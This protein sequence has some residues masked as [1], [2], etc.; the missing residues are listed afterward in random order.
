M[1]AADIPNAPNDFSNDLATHYQGTFLDINRQYPV[2]A[3]TPDT[4]ANTIYGR[5][6][7][8]G[9]FEEATVVC[10]FIEQCGCDQYQT[11][12]AD[13]VCVFKAVEGSGSQTLEITAL[14]FG[15]YSASLSNVEVISEAVVTSSIVQLTANYRNRQP[16]CEAM[17]AVTDDQYEVSGM[18]CSTNAGGV[19]THKV[20]VDGITTES[21]CLAASAA[22][23]ATL[24]TT[25][26]NGNGG[27]SVCMMTPSADTDSSRAQWVASITTQ[28]L[29]LHANDAESRSYVYEWREELVHD[30][31]LATRTVCTACA[32]I[33][34]Q[35]QL[36]SDSC[37]SH[38]VTD[39]ICQPKLVCGLTDY[40]TNPSSAT[41]NRECS[42]L[43][44]CNPDSDT[45]Q[46]TAPTLVTH[47]TEY[48][49]G[50]GQCTRTADQYESNRLCA[51]QPQCQAETAE[52][53]PTAPP[54]SALEPRTCK[55][56]DEHF[57]DAA[58]WDN[59]AVV[60]AA[61]P[62]APAVCDLDISCNRCQTCDP[63]TEYES[64][65]CTADHDRVCKQRLAA[66]DTGFQLFYD[67]T[68]A[69]ETHTTNCASVPA[70]CSGTQ[71]E[72][73]NACALNTPGAACAVG[74][75]DCNY[76]PG[77]GAAT[78]TLNVDETGCSTA[79]A[80]AGCV[81]HA[82]VT[83]AGDITC[84]SKQICGRGRFEDMDAVAGLDTLG[85][86]MS[87]DVVY[88]AGQSGGVHSDRVCKDMSPI[89]RD[90][91][92]ACADGT[93]PA[94]V[95]LPVIKAKFVKFNFGSTDGNIGDI[96][97]QQVFGTEFADTCSNPAF[98]SDTACT[99]AAH[100]WATGWAPGSACEHP[101]CTARTLLPTSET[102]TNALGSS[103]ACTSATEKVVNLGSIQAFQLVKITTA[104]S[105]VAVSY[106]DDGTTYLPRVDSDSE[107]DIVIPS[108]SYIKV[109]CDADGGAGA[110]QLG[111][112]KMYT[113]DRSVCT[114]Q[115]CL[116]NEWESAPPTYDTVD[117]Q[118]VAVND[119]TCSPL[120]VCDGDQYE[121]VY[122]KKRYLNQ[123]PNADFMYISQRE[124]RYFADYNSDAASRT[125]T[126]FDPLQWEV[127]Y[128]AAGNPALDL[129]VADNDRPSDEC[130]D[131]GPV[132]GG[133][134]GPTLCKY[135]TDR[136]CPVRNDARADDCLPFY[137]VSHG[138][139]VT[140]FTGMFW[141]VNTVKATLP[142]AIVFA[143]AGSC[144]YTVDTA[145]KLLS[146][147]FVGICAA[148]T[149]ACPDETDA[150]DATDCAALV[151][152]LAEQQLS[153]AEAAEQRTLSA[154]DNF[155][156]TPVWTDINLDSD[157]KEAALAN[158]EM[159]RIKIT[160][161]KIVT[162][163]DGTMRTVKIGDNTCQ[164]T[165]DGVT[166]TTSHQILNTPPHLAQINDDICIAG[167]QHKF[168]VAAVPPVYVSGIPHACHDANAKTGGL[169]EYK[170]SLPAFEDSARNTCD[171]Y[172][173]RREYC[174]LFGDLFSDQSVTAREACC[175]CGGGQRAESFTLQVTTRDPH[176][177]GESWVLVRNEDDGWTI[178]DPS[179][180]DG[181]QTQHT[182]NHYDAPTEDW[183]VA[184]RIDTVTFE[185]Y[186]FD[187]QPPVLECPT[188]T[189]TVCTD[190]GIDAATAQETATVYLNGPDEG[191]AADVI[192][193]TSD[194]E[195][196]APCMLY[197]TAVTDNVN[198]NA[199]YDAAASYSQTLQ[200]H[201]CASEHGDPGGKTW[202]AA[203]AVSHTLARATVQSGT[204]RTTY[205]HNDYIYPRFLIGT[206]TVTFTALDAY[207][208]RGS[209]VITMEVKDCAPPLMTCIDVVVHTAPGVC[210]CTVENLSASAI[211]N[212]GIL[213]EMTLVEQASGRPID[214]DYKF[215]TGV[216]TVESIATDKSGALCSLDNQNEEEICEADTPLKTSC[217][218]TVTCSDQEDPVVVSCPDVAA[219][220]Q[221]GM[222]HATLYHPNLN[223][224][225]T[226][227][228]QELVAT[229][230]SGFVTTPRYED[231]EGVIIDT[232]YQFPWYEE[233]VVSYVVAD[234][235][236]NEARCS[237][238][239]QLNCGSDS[240]RLQ[241]SFELPAAM[242]CS[243]DGI[244]AVE[245]SMTCFTAAQI[246]GLAV[247]VDDPDGG[248]RTAADYILLSTTAG[249][250]ATTGF[251]TSWKPHMPASSVWLENDLNAAR[252]SRYDNIGAATVDTETFDCDDTG[253]RRGT[254]ADNLPVGHAGQSN[255]GADPPELYGAEKFYS[256]ITSTDPRWIIDSG[257]N[258]PENV[259]RAVAGYAFVDN[260]DGPAN[261]LYGRLQDSIMGQ[262]YF[263]VT[264]PDGSIKLDLG[265]VRIPKPHTDLTM[266][267]LRWYKYSY[268]LYGAGTLTVSV[269]GTRR[270][271]GQPTSPIVLTTTSTENVCTLGQC[272][273]EHV[274]EQFGESWADW[275]RAEFTLEVKCT[276]E[277]NQVGCAD[278]RAYFDNFGVGHRGCTDPDAKNFD[279]NAVFE[280]TGL[281]CT[282]DDD[283]LLPEDCCDHNWCCADDGADNFD[284]KCP[285]ALNSRL[286]KTHQNRNGD[287]T[288]EDWEGCI[289]GAAGDT[290]LDSIEVDAEALEAQQQVLQHKISRVLAAMS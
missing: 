282:A 92:F 289:W 46:L 290:T 51:C 58:S 123:H 163:S 274:Q 30:R 45:F 257:T 271:T 286:K 60:Y 231:A 38:F 279:S 61:V 160:V 261:Q 36:S 135:G 59:W 25:W 112:T 179:N 218:F 213:P 277:Q 280:K 131:G 56:Q 118:T 74:G 176:A 103:H 193:C 33:Q 14:C 137:H 24:G 201:A 66:C 243:T 237:F 161:S 128:L 44:A 98:L 239:V 214:P 21:A 102:C 230:N 4:P 134:P 81:Y 149:A 198:A 185:L 75:G 140:D 162:D 32:Y 254:T 28:A 122:P 223:P 114:L 251:T 65:P 200:E 119:R 113:E 68:H 288:G 148:E 259:E 158:S 263:S 52:V 8:L 69:V 215:Q 143:D 192:S 80:A 7:E 22:H 157:Q 173:A 79:S 141:N 145:A 42:E 127:D 54:A 278:V 31:V 16:T 53:D 120:T 72:D 132:P 78:C 151:A 144:Y 287:P 35:G 191:A 258:K 49:D 111:C 133:T 225:G 266:R 6:P 73:G 188:T 170:D 182:N 245:T 3:R 270:D 275:S 196:V 13:E 126:T 154:A 262:Q 88:I 142:D 229:D 96:L 155:F 62:T 175:A 26:Q 273:W 204:S 110:L 108:N 71:D 40:V 43:Q 249:S 281:E 285:P 67:A 171:D 260:M 91:Q 248:G 29:C 202:Q 116:C 269:V 194:G 272:D 99:G 226:V 63:A 19:G 93:E 121:S 87:S 77:S 216:T 159:N 207:L 247:L 255:R 256:A 180:G 117:G 167:G 82:A 55:C 242:D 205:Q 20:Q 34:S 181:N 217:T 174:D 104:H 83:P 90:Y 235:F 11:M 152:C 1:E 109:G 15:D 124:C 236:G 232:T 206:Y 27:G 76:D 195:V 267:T 106:S 228:F 12:P 129:C 268:Q 224:R 220:C 178:E 50:D 156:M 240:W 41:A 252:S 250:I 100:T 211:D 97:V 168:P 23:A 233:R 5:Y 107:A 197:P 222:E 139:G 183:C 253:I 130:N 199:Q 246:G 190:G 85:R 150:T 165:T 186:V 70:A 212:S 138:M 101:D 84:M 39:R 187:N 94:H 115:V 2:D 264:D 48:N 221:D 37:S 166:R 64:T 265:V 283:G 276:D 209:C 208:N 147:D 238:A 146:W 153:A 164:T 210:Y 203:P 169:V 234:P 18:V 95:F 57:K 189:T 9:V 125:Y 219:P 241:E 17:T 227:R 284:P 172:T 10:S 136:D 86:E 105:N 244:A 184:Q 177:D 89:T 47:T